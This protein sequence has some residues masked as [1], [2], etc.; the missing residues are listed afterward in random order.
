MA[1]ERYYSLDKI[2]KI[3]AQYKLLVGQRSNGKSFAVKYDCI[4]RAYKNKTKFVYL[5]RYDKNIKTLAVNAYFAD[6]PVDKITKGDYTHVIC[7][8]GCI[9]FANYDIDQMK[10]I[11]GPEIGR[12]VAL[13]VAEGYKSQAFVNY[14]RIIFEEFLTNRTYLENEPTELM[15]LVSTI[16]RDN[17]GV[18]YLIG[19]TISRVCP[20]FTEWDLRGT[21]TLKPG[22][23]QTYDFHRTDVDGKDILTTIAVEMC[24]SLGSPS[25]M[26][27]GRSAKAIAGGHWEVYD[28]PKLPGKLEDFTEVYELLIEREGFRFVMKML[29]DNK[30]GGAFLYVYPHSGTRKIPRIITDTF[31][32]D[33]LITYTLMDENE[34]EKLIK[35]LMMQ[36]K[37]CYADN[38][39][40]SDFEMLIAK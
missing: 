4:E 25:K 16:F 32:T 29:I 1:R 2:K 24:E 35:Q 7:D 15:N 14:D 30:T 10:Y 17:E 34:D 5:R 11:K 39:T 27:F 40:A 28:R 33:P 21:L 13:N 31:S 3:Y 19:N 20:Y 23:I 26:I 8:R 36:R 22:T 9:Y 18:V 12:A 38:I 6:M 37:I